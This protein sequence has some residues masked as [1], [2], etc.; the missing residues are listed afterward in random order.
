M[1]ERPVDPLP[2][3]DPRLHSPFA[4]RLPGPSVPRRKLLGRWRLALASELLSVRLHI[5]DT[6]AAGDLRP[7]A[8]S[9]NSADIR[10]R[11]H[12][13]TRPLARIRSRIPNVPRREGMPSFHS[14]GTGWLLQPYY[15]RT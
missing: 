10:P 2:D 13:L 5:G 3:Q 11:F 1:P 8:L 12:L 7:T 14:A 15:A 4:G 6:T 9:Y